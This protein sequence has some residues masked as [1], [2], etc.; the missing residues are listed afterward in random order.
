MH[1]VFHYWEMFICY[2]IRRTKGSTSDCNL[3]MFDT[4][5][6]EAVKFIKWH[7]IMLPLMLNLRKMY[8]KIVIIF[9]W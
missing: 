4:N 6:F 1:Y 7:Y 8:T 3:A 5:I 9:R 2:S